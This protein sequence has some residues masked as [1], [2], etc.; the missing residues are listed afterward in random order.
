MAH[1]F[2]SMSVTL[3]RVIIVGYARHILGRGA[4]LVPPI[5]EQPRKKGPLYKAF[6]RTLCK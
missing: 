4:F 6:Q 1:T 5:H 2:M 3:P